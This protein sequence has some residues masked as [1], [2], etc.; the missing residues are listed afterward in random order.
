MVTLLGDGISGLYY[1]VV[2]EE[3][4]EEVYFWLLRISD[5][6]RIFGEGVAHE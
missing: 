6:D 4:K 2:G 1:S 3:C 5:V